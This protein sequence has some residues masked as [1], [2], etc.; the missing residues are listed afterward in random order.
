M[1]HAKTVGPEL[2]RLVRK[3][4][5]T[6]VKWRR[7][8][9]QYPEIA[10]Q[11][12]KT[13]AF[14]KSELKQLGLKIL[15]LGMK[16]GVLAE[17]KGKRSGPTVAIRSDMDALPVTE[18]TGLPFASRINGRMHACGHD[19]HMAT[20]LGAAAALVELKE[21]P[22]GN[23]RFI[24]QPA[25]E[26]PPGG[27][28]FMI[29]HG[30][31]EN[32]DTVFGLHCDPHLPTGTVGLCDGSM[33]AMVSDFD[34]VIRGRGGHASRP[35]SAVDAIVTAAAVVEAI[36]KIVSRETDPAA[37]VV[38]TVG[39]IE[40]GTARNVIADRVTLVCTARSLATRVGK[41][42]VALIR[43]TVGGVCRAHGATFEM[44]EQLAYPILVND[45]HTNRLYRSVFGDMF[46]PK[47]VR[48]AEPIL[49][50]EDF[51]YYL[52]KVP[53]AMF[54]LGVGNRKIGADKPWHSSDF[55]ADEEAM[56][57]GTSLLVGSTL[58]F[59]EEQTV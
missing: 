44:I 30:A 8:L 28:V 5:P 48:Q 41:K 7:H 51:A 46:G 10:N 26:E 27:A 36:Q 45:A 32:V 12:V 50:G 57:Y 37:P 59:L 18:E 31:L 58:R 25:E 11:E 21:K 42:V 19:L 35:Q 47:K 22:P 23:V 24:F 2:L 6:Q 39:R 4:Y 1:P 14:L 52:Q 17:L 33:M 54:R 16:T 13:T 43:R 55:I 34:L 20:V 15:R 38:I 49:G 56:F 3:Q 9:H 53:G 29:E 40:G